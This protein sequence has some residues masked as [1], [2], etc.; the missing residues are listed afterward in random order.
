M[1]RSPSALK[2]VAN[3]MTSSTGRT[4]SATPS[5]NATAMGRGNSYAWPKMCS[6]N[7]SSNR[8]TAAGDSDRKPSHLVSPDLKKGTANATRRRREDVSH[9]TEP[10]QNFLQRIFD[11]SDVYLHFYCAHAGLVGCRAPLPCS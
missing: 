2:R 3:P 7:S 10:L 4:I 11:A 9:S 5:K 6:L 8:N 1:T